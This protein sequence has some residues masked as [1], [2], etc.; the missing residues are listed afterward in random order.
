M[1]GGD[2]EGTEVVIDAAATACRPGRLAKGSDEGQ[3]EGGT[4]Q[5]VGRFREATDHCR[6]ALALKPD[7]APAYYLLGLVNELQGMPDDAAGAALR[8]ALADVEGD[9]LAG[10]LHSLGE[11]RDN[12]SRPARQNGPH[13]R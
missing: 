7:H 6:Q 8:S 13:P 3:V 9:L 11:R 5:S 10:I 12:Q 1:P 4:L 2:S